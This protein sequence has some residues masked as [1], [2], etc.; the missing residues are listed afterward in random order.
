MVHPFP[1]LD[2]CPR[3]RK[4]CVCTKI[5]VCTFAAVCFVMAPNLK[6]LTCSAGGGPSAV[7]PRPCWSYTGTKRDELW[8]QQLRGWLSAWLRRVKGAKEKRKYAQRDS[9][10]LKPWEMPAN[11]SED[12]S[13]WK[14]ISGRLEV[15]EGERER[16]PTASE[17][18][19]HSGCVR[20]LD[21]HDAFM[22]TVL[23]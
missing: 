19:G 22:G 13:I 11:L 21:R 1:L 23:C 15:G 3:G 14:Q 16:E 12:S 6:Q 17:T 5:C 8:I 4:T 20:Y 10:Y 2:I 9:V 18:F 7:E